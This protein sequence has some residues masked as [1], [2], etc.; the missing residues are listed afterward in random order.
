M[1][2]EEFFQQH[3]KAALAFS[4]GTD[5]AYLLSEAVRAG[6]DCRAYYVKTEFQPEFELRDARALA[7]ELGAD[8]TVLSLSVLEE[9]AVVSNPAD[10]CYYCKQTIFGAICR[11]AGAD[12]Y[13]LILDG[14]NASDRADDRPGMRALREQNVV[15]PL[16]LCG[17]TKRQVR[18]RSRM[19]G[20]FT[21]DKPAYACLATRVPAGRRITAED[22][23]KIEQAETFLEELGFRDFRVRLS[24]GGCLI[25]VTE[26]QF[27]LALRNRERITETLAGSFGRVSLDLTPRPEEN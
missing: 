7:E 9:E 3:P 8:L 18:E 2:L 13:E 4:G 1:T 19:N 26:R 10:R 5:S 12:G 11:Q 21:W 17:L 22:L 24:E 6:C 27:E 20:L 25:Q 15:S 16:R 23:Q 14:T